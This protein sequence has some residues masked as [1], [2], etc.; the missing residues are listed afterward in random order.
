M[1]KIYSLFAALL[2]ITAA[3]A[4]TF[5][6]TSGKWSDVSVWGGKY[7]GTTIKAEDEVIITGQITMNTSIVVEGTLTVAK[8]GGMV[9]MKDLVIAKGGAFVNNGNTVMKRILNRGSVKNNMIM[10]AI[11][12]IQ[13]ESSMENNSIMSGNSFDN[14]GG[15]AAGNNGAYFVN[16]TVNSSPASKFGGDVK[17]YY[18]NANES[19]ATSASI[20]NVETTVSSEAVL[21]SVINPLRKDVSVFSIEKST[22]GVNYA[23]LEMVTNVTKDSD[24]AMSFTDYTI[25]NQLT[26]YRVTAITVNGDNTVLPITAVKAP[27]NGYAMAR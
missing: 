18:G 17:V 12:D 7:I 8:G 11:M 25:N 20:M 2:I 13:N 27:T 21:L 24:V 14:F 23:L 26:Y 4:K 19:Q 16:N 22:D 1:K 9:G 10:E 15:T 5:T 6:V 3:N